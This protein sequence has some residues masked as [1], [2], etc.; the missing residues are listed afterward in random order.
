[1]LIVKSIVDNE[2]IA[3]YVRHR[4]FRGMV[5]GDAAEEPA[6]TKLDVTAESSKRAW[7]A[8]D[9]P[10]PPIFRPRRTGGDA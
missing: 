4:R 2:G 5:D 6:T 1:M 8:S 3:N 10:R 9:H 7:S